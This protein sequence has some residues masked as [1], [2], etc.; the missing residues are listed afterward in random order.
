MRGYLY[1]F[2]ILLL[3]T[4]CAHGGH[5]S[6]RA[7]TGIASWYGPDFNGKLTASGEVYDMNAFTAAHK[8]LPLGTIVEVKNLENKRTVRLTIND[9]G[10][11]VRGRIIDLSYRGA[12]ELGVV[13]NGTARVSVTPVGRDGRYIK[14]IRVSDKG[15]GAY[16]VQ[17]GAFTSKERAEKLLRALDIERSGAYISKAKVSGK[18]FYRVRAGDFASRS[19]ALKVANSLAYEGYEAVLMRK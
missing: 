10:P 18:V 5:D 1:L 14:Y 11:F 19:S 7:S 4:A 6:M 3:L 16:T 2:T 13:K 9:R 8:T 15:S 17:I 12:V